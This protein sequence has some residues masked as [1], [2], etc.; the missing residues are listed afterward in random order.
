MTSKNVRQGSGD[1]ESR[2]FAL[3][4]G[5]WGVNP[6]HCC[7]VC[8]ALLH[9]KGCL[10]SSC[11]PQLWQCT[12]SCPLSSGEASGNAEWPEGN[13]NV[14]KTAAAFLETPT[15]CKIPGLLL[16][17]HLIPPCFSFLFGTS[18][19]LAFLLHLCHLASLPAT[20][21]DFPSGL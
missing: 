21:S 18:C 2:A 12:A 4:A 16:L 1:V 15:S 9:P 14:N 10:L 20:S 11:S 13:A 6:E 3:L 17:F 19:S 5:S 7:G 8:R